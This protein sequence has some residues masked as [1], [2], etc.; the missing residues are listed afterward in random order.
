MKRLNFESPKLKKNTKIMTTK[1]WLKNTS[2]IFEKDRKK[3]KRYQKMSN[4]THLH[5]K[6]KNSI[7]V[8]KK[9]KENMFI[10][11]VIPLMS[12]LTCQS[13]YVFVGRLQISFSN[14]LV[15]ADS[16]WGSPVFVLLCLLT[17]YSLLSNILDTFLT[18]FLPLNF[19]NTHYNTCSFLRRKTNEKMKKMSGTGEWFV[20]MIK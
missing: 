15:A 20:I 2:T 16:A 18:A 4:T 9:R 5:T 10:V 11:F 6:E 13:L 14:L 8:K 3:K 17:T 19:G 7:N 1:F 12:H